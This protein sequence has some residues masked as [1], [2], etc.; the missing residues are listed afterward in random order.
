M[1]PE[2]EEII[3]RDGQ[4][5]LSLSPVA[6]DRWLDYVAGAWFGGQGAR[7]QRRS[8]REQIA[9]F[10]DPRFVTLSY[11]GRM[12]GSYVIDQQA[13]Q[14]NTTRLT[15]FYRGLLSVDD[16]FRSRRL[17]AQMVDA[18]LS[19]VEQR[20][21]ASPHA[22]LT[23]GCVD[24]DNER[25]LALL[26]SRGMQTFATLSHKLVYRQFKRRA[27]PDDALQYALSDAATSALTG[28]YG[29]QYL[30]SRY[31][32]RGDWISYGASA[33][34]VIACRY[35]GTELNLEPMPGIAGFVTEK[36]MGLLPAARRRFDPR[37][38]RYV[39]LT[40]ILWQP[41]CE[42]RWSELIE[43]LMVVHDCHFVALTLNPEHAP[44]GAMLDSGVLGRDA[45]RR[46]TRLLLIGKGLGQTLP[47]MDSVR[48]TARDL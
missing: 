22:A 34:S 29:G 38:F 15:G 20:A 11:A 40:D 8:V 33:E 13:L 39:S 21:S 42:Q 7:Y 28:Q 35:A 27:L 32:E 24:A 3:W 41:G 5:V 31:P 4:A 25:S 9:R 23:Y 45:A 30:Q 43:H 19:W 18:S 36:L 47:V 2:S 12:V 37:R 44:H 6:S 10:E 14:L 1:K 16:A 26:R 46:A 17:G 48:L